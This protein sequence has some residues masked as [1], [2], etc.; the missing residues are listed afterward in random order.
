LTLVNLTSKDI[1]DNWATLEHA[2]RTAVPAH[3][4]TQEPD[5]VVNCLQALLEKDLMAYFGVQGTT[6]RGLVILQ[7]LEDKILKQKHMLVLVLYGIG[8]L[9]DEA[10]SGGIE[11]IQRIARE[12][13]CKSIIAYSNNPRVIQMV[14][15]M[16]GDASQTLI[17][18]GII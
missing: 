11:G 8:F 16:G 14:R 5:F 2:L 15:R 6:L 4:Q 3:I 17:N 9:D 1:T 18:I 12:Y 7:L 13:N 10:W